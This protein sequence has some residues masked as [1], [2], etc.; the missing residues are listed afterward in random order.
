MGTFHARKLAQLTEEGE[1][2]LAGICDREAQRAEEVA[3]ELRVPVL[4]TLEEVIAKAQAAC[5]AV[6]TVHHAE[7]AGE[8][9]AAGLDVLLE[10]PI[11]TTRAE[12]NR[13]IEIAAR[14][15]RVLQIGHVERFSRAFREI[16]PVLTRP[17][18][19]EV[20]RLGPYPNR[21]TDVSVV[22]DLMIHDLDIVA[23]LVGAEVTHVE[24]V[25]VPVLSSTE[26]IANARVRF[27]NECVL[28]LTASRVSMERLR[29]IR[30]FQSDAYI[31][32]DLGNH[33]ITVVRREG[34]PGGDSPPRITA[35]TLEF[36]QSDAL[37]AQDRAFVAALRERSAPV[38][39]GE[40]GLRALDLALRIQE[41]M[42]D[43]EDLD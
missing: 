7:V 40:D 32:I 27:A 6:P 2:E 33:V 16:R 20:H 4:A 36:D 3:A 28:N 39:T 11:A 8:L 10:K 37:L 42:P 21:A 38:V 41:S 1:A 19:I 15:Q 31:S 24:A 23:Q 35:E 17:R 22:L 12:A 18:F 34:K 25:G 9:L 29:K 13:L 30:L 5:V 14:E 43:I 26:D